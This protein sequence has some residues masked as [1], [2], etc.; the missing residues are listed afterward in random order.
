[1]ILSFSEPQYFPEQTK[2]LALLSLILHFHL[3]RVL[4]DLAL[5]FLKLALNLRF[6]SFF[7]NHLGYRI[8]FFLQIQL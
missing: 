4:L 7:T 1:M 2:Q 3:T 5:D 8:S 6:I